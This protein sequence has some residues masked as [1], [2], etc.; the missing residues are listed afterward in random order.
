MR[1]LK[2]VGLVRGSKRPDNLTV[3]TPEG[4]RVEG[5]RQSS[6]SPCCG[7]SWH[8]QPS[9][10]PTCR[11]PSWAILLSFQ[12]ASADEFRSSRDRG[13]SAT[14]TIGWNLTGGGSPACDRSRGLARGRGATELFEIGS[15]VPLD[16]SVASL[17]QAL[18]ARRSARVSASPHRAATFAAASSADRDTSLVSCRGLERRRMAGVDLATLLVR[19]ARAQ[20]LAW[21]TGARPFAA[22]GTELEGLLNVRLA[23]SRHRDP[24]REFAARGA[25]HEF[26]DVLVAPR[27]DSPRIATARQRACW[28][29]R[30]L[31]ATAA[32]A[33]SP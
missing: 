17:S 18:R 19:L 4:F 20:S 23:W 26:A 6:R 33:A 11:P 22:M 29:D 16:G 14:E 3:V 10:S 28:T 7:W 30:C 12:T 15:P 32:T 27:S 2:R 24:H 13:S 1:A 25:Q 9:I 31:H 21:A 5:S 8:Y